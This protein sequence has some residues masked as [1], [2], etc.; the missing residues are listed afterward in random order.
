MSSNFKVKL[1]PTSAKKRK[2]GS[3]RRKTNTETVI[4]DFDTESCFFG[5]VESIISSKQCIV[6]DMKTNKLVHCSTRGF[7]TRQLSKGSPVVFAYLRGDTVG[8]VIEA[9]NTDSLEDLCYHFKINFESASKSCGLSTNVNKI[10]N[11]AI[12]TLSIGVHQD[13]QQLTTVNEDIES[14]D[15]YES[16]EEPPMDK[17]GNYI[18]KDEDEDEE[19]EVEVEVEIVSKSLNTITV[20]SEESEEEQVPVVVTKPVEKTSKQDRKAL[21]IKRKNDRKSR[22]D[23]FDRY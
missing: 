7:Y 21:D 19:V 6:R 8:E 12:P 23:N 1:G 11:S 20:E 16:E 2:G 17:F 5:V 9:Y 10:D 13:V 18:V 4:T 22:R 14:D 3:R 15:D